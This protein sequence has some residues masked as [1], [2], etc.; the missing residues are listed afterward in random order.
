MNRSTQLSR[1]VRNPRA[2]G[3]RILPILDG[4]DGEFVEPA[5]RPPRSVSRDV[6]VD[7]CPRGGL[8]MRFQACGFAYVGRPG[9][10]DAT[11]AACIDA[12]VRDAV[13]A[14]LVAVGT[15]EAWLAVLHLADNPDATRTRQADLSL[16]KTVVAEMVRSA[17]RAVAEATK[18]DGTAPNWS[19]G[20][21]PA[22]VSR[23]L[24]HASPEISWTDLK[25]FQG[26]RS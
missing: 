24:R 17:P 23:V 21:V 18:Q 1:P 15:C 5:G 3:I 25:N 2:G 9:T 22:A 4:A 16:M 6:V 11:E 20:P 7:F 19:V 14:R 10:E 8:R 13:E 12:A 26:G